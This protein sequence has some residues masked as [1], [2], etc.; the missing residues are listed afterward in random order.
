MDQHQLT[1][2]VDLVAL[3]VVVRGIPFDAQT[4]RPSAP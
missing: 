4:A 1:V 2:F 3:V